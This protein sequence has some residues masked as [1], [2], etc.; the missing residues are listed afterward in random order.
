MEALGAVA[1]G[2]QVAALSVKVVETLA[3]FVHDARAV[4]ETN[5][6]ILIQVENLI[7]TVR[8]VEGVM[9]RRESKRGE[10]PIS[11]DEAKALEKT[12]KTLKQTIKNINVLRD[13]I[14]KLGG[15]RSQPNA[16]RKGWI[17]LKTQIQSESI[18]HIEKMLD[19]NLKSLQL[20][21]PC[22]QL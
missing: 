18:I 12:A 15:G 20:I 3:R 10:R 1:A 8:T 4:A 21:I 11:D 22:T 6:R 14:E 5:S 16:W 2:L 7:E 13:K 19:L 9:K 17:Q